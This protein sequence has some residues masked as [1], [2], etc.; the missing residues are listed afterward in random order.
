[1]L[2]FSALIL[3]IGQQRVYLFVNL[4]LIF[5]LSNGNKITTVFCLLT[6]LMKYKPRLV[7]FESVQSTLYL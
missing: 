7:S 5:F 3:L 4:F 1:M 2:I 6:Y